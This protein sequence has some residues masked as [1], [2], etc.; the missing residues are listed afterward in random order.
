MGLPVVVFCGSEDANGKATQLSNATTMDYQQSNSDSF[1][2][3]RDYSEM[4]ELGLSDARQRFFFSAAQQMTTARLH[5]SLTPTALSRGSDDQQCSWAMNLSNATHPFLLFIMFLLHP[6]CARRLTLF[7]A[8]M[9][10]MTASQV[11]TLISTTSIRFSKAS[12]RNK[13]YS[14][15]FP[16]C[17]ILAAP[18]PFSSKQ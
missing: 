10:V 2:A 8:T 14:F 3:D 4:G 6:R 17:G 18:A 16:T 1:A 15:S 7:P 9:A 12:Q 11:A 13:S 5:D